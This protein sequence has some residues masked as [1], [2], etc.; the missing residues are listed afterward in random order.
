MGCHRARPPSI[1]SCST[2]TVRPRRHH[3]CN[4]IPKIHK[5][6]IS[7]SLA[8]FAI[9]NVHKLRALLNTNTNSTE[10]R[11]AFQ[12]YT[13]LNLPPP[14]WFFERADDCVK[15]FVH[16]QMRRQK[17]KNAPQNELNIIKCACC[18]SSSSTSAKR[19]FHA[20]RENQYFSLIS[21]SSLLSRSFVRS[22]VLSSLFLHI[23][24]ISFN[25]LMY[26]T[27]TPHTYREVSDDVWCIWNWSTLHRLRQ[28]TKMEKSTRAICQHMIRLDRCSP[29]DGRPG[30]QN[31]WIHNSF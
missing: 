14:Q 13:R 6:R 25:A 8:L 26:Y 24:R 31:K 27:C 11:F 28:K 3:K 18:S 16:T 20:V 12:R 29:F 9:S 23:F 5:F 19:P 21:F 1:F 17:K 22:I 10:V 15:V 4:C 7:L 30:E 2:S